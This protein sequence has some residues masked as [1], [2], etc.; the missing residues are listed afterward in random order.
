MNEG[1]PKLLAEALDVMAE[2]GVEAAVIGGCARNAY[3]EVRSTR[4]VDLVV[5][6][7]EERYPTLTE[8][9]ARRG[10]HRGSAV[11][12][13]HGGVPDLELFRD[14]GGRRLDLLY[15]HTEFERSALSR[16]ETREPYAGVRAP[17]VSPEDLVVYKLIAG[18]TQDRLDIVAMIEALEPHGRVLDWSYVERWCD[19]WEI[20]GALERLRAELA[21]AE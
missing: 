9:L 8:L 7:S 16:R 18:R 4:D 5:A 20:R 3:A 13:E 6:V 11:G 14:A 2:A 12:A 10:F 17:V 21:G 1:I 15:A 19:A